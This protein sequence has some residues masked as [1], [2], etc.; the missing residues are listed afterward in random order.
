[1]IQVP[2]LL[3][4]VLVLVALLIALWP[5]W[6]SQLPFLAKLAIEFVLVV[7]AVAVSMPRRPKSAA[8]SGPTA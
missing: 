5:I 3:R 4:T 8:R 2:R 6:R 1:M 7:L